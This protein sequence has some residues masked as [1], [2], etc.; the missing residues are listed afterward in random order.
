MARSKQSTTAVAEPAVPM[1]TVEWLRTTTDAASEG[2]AHIGPRHY[3]GRIGQQV[4]IRA[5]DAEILA[6]SGYVKTVASEPEQVA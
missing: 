3:T 1:V 5:D 4:E 2:G 6:A